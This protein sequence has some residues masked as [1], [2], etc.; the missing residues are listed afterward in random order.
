LHTYNLSVAG[1]RKMS[2]TDPICRYCHGTGFILCTT[3]RDGEMAVA[4]SCRSEKAAVADAPER[5]SGM[6]AIRA[7]A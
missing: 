6:T 5:E 1:R 7:S 2:T 4:C 3:G